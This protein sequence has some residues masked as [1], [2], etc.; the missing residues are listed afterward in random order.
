MS[1]IPPELDEYLRATLGDGIA[2]DPLLGD[3]SV[4]AYYRVL[5]ADG[6]RFM[7]AYYPEAVRDV[8]GR[9]LGAWD[10]IREHAR[11]PAVVSHCPFAVVQQDVG[12]VTLFEL[13]ER[14]PERAYTLYRRSIDLLVRFQRSP[15]AAGGI[16]PPFTREDFLRELEMTTEFW[17]RRMC[18]VEDEARL[19]RLAGCLRDLSAAVARHPYVLCHRDFHGQNLHIVNDDIYMIDFQDLRMGPDTYDLA[20]LLRDRGVARSLGLRA[21]RELIDYYRDRAGSDCALPR[22]YFETLLQRSIKIVGTFARQSIVRERHHY[23]AYIPPTLESI[24]LC[25]DELPDY[26]DL[27]DAFP[28]QAADAHPA[29]SSRT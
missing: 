6:K 11:V 1:G 18:G 17:V 21:E 25:V 7:V 24:R 19:A 4:R 10:A 22:R 9:Y 29:F 14:E 16:N 23:L 15:V 8:I 20:S 5:A 28:L 27:L 12:D 26:R 2:V 3:A 13:L